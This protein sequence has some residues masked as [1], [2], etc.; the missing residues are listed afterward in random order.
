MSRIITKELAEKIAKKL[1]ARLSLRPN[2]AHDIFEVYESGR[3]ITF[4]GIRRGSEKDKGHDHIPHDLH[5][6]PRDAR[7]HASNTS[8]FCEKKGWCKP[9]RS[10][11]QTQRVHRPR[12]NR[13]S[14]QPDLQRP[15]LQLCNNYEG[16]V[17]QGS[18]PCPPPLIFRSPLLK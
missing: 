16:P 9:H 8:S 18:S 5:V 11:H 10:P 7:S 14:R 15:P 13:E 4:F 12:I 2:K 17:P 6:G 3:L 1:K